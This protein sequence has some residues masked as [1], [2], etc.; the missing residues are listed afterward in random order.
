M[1]L[2]VAFMC[3]CYMFLASLVNWNSYYFFETDISAF[4]DTWTYLLLHVVGKVISFKPDLLESSLLGDELHKKVYI[5]WS[6]FSCA[7]MFEPRT[8]ITKI[9]NGNSINVGVKEDFENELP[10][11]L[12]KVS[13]FTEFIHFEVW[14][15]RVS[16]DDLSQQSYYR[17]S[18]CL[19]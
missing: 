9:D 18:S 3:V 15:W 12:I 6:L 7:R 4:W 19:R 10:D 2:F 11:V 14:D 8:V 5:T 16:L 13:V 17:Q 1:I